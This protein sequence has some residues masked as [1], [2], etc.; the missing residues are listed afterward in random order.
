VFLSASLTLPTM[1]APEGPLGF[2]PKQAIS[3]TPQLYDELVSDSMVQLARASLACV[4]TPADGAKFHDL[5]CG[6]GAATIA[7]MERMQGHPTKKINVTATDLLQKALDVYT[8]HA[9]NNGWPVEVL[10]MDAN[11]QQFAENT[12]DIV[13]GNALLFVL[14][15]DGIR[16]IQETYRTLKPGG[17]AIF[18]SWA[19]VPNMAPLMAAHQAT[20]PPGTPPPRAGLDKWSE[21]SFLRK[22]MH[23]GGFPSGNV[24]LRQTDIFVHTSEMDRYVNMLWSF[25]GGTSSV[26]WLASDEENWNKATAAIK[27]ELRKTPGYQELED[28]RNLIK[29][30][31]NIAVV[32]KPEPG[33]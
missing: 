24:S 27:E 26:G 3:P 4:A 29:F 2:K 31:A 1:N 17:T 14:E 8:K 13:I 12:F 30:V 28:G 15:K 16:A 7:F 32:T 11:E 19:Y 9:E 25:I 21:G 23:Q 22:I 10:N 20:R 6:T 33:C 5:G 18:N